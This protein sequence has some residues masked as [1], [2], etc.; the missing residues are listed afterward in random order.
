MDQLNV[1]GLP[2]HLVTMSSVLLFI[3][4]RVRSL[5][6]PAYIVCANPEK[7]SQIRSVDWL[8]QLFEAADLVIPDGI[9]IVIAARLLY[10]RKLTR[11][12][13]ADLMQAICAVAPAHNYR[14]FIYGSSETTNRQAVEVLRQR[15]PGIDIVGVQ[16]G[17]FPVEKMDDLISRINNASPDILFVG[18]G[19]PRQEMWIQHH[20]P[21]L[22]V[23]VI[24][25]IGGTL[26]VVAGRV[27][28]A[29]PWLQAAGMEWLYRL[30]CQPSRIWRQLQLV[31]FVWEVIAATMRFRI[32]SLGRRFPQGPT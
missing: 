25:G 3:D 22:R 5:S 28:R 29:P 14:I 32:F 2:V 9:G 23:K 11:V 1:L 27:K 15:H 12:A 13:G 20:L 24:Q 21:K 7:V 10:G 19:S 31:S 30:L 26:D 6:S 8:R 17:Y 16:H 18:L 4:D